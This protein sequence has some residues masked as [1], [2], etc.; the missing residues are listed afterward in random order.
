MLRELYTCIVEYTGQCMSERM[1]HYL[2]SLVHS[3]EEVEKLVD[4]TVSFIEEV[5]RLTSTY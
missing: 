2:P 1:P 5:K 4:I 3:K